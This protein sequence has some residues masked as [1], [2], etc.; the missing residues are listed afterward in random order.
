MRKGI[1]LSGGLIVEHGIGTTDSGPRYVKVNSRANVDD[2]V[3]NN[4]WYSG[5]DFSVGV[6]IGIG[7]F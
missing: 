7:L 5:R 3:G 1:G 4:D 2:A 6:K